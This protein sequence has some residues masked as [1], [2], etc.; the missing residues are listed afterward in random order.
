MAEKD[1]SE[2]VWKEALDA[3]TGLFELILILSIFALVFVSCFAFEG[4][5][6]YFNPQTRVTVWIAPT[7]V[8]LLS[9][10]HLIIML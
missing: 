3:A 9:S 6:Y 4:R 2:V 5:L 1:K 7:F 8:I 10:L